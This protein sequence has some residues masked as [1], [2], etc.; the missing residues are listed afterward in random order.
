MWDQVCITNESV[1]VEV[2]STFVTDARAH[3]HTHEISLGRD[4]L[5]SVCNKNRKS[6]VLIWYR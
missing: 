2:W 4:A 5:Q 3:T 1:A 6:E